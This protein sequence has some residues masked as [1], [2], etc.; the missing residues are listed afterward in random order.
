MFP[1]VTIIILNAFHTDNLIECLNSLKETDYPNFRTIIVSF[2]S[3][4]IGNLGFSNFPDLTQIKLSGKDIGPSAMHNV[5]LASADPSSKYVAFLDDDT[6]VEKKWLSEL[7]KCI[8]RNDEI[9]AVQ[10]KIMIYG[11]DNILNTNGNKANYLAVGWSEGFNTNDTRC[12][13]I[14]AI[15][16]PSGAAMILRKSALSKIDLFDEDFFIYCDDLDVGLRMRLAGYTILYCPYSIVFH[17]YK[18]IRTK[19]SFYYLNRNRIFTFLKL[20]ELKT[21]FLLFPPYLLYEIF[22]IGYAILNGYL[23]SVIKSYISIIINLK[24]II[25]KRKTIKKY[26]IINDRCLINQ[27]EAGINFSE[28]SNPAVNSL[29]NPFLIKYKRYLLQSKLFER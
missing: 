10:S 18:F 22:V 17:K 20:Y 26:K 19:N 14:K 29:L 5:G 27:L 7:V 23:R 4:D 13:K 16:F 3:I 9:G 15:S 12:D 21:Y 24:L 11:K 6:I 28:I 2:S 25:K 1:L 8:E